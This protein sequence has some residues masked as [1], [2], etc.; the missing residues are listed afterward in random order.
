M[1]KYRIDV[2]ATAERQ[3]RRLPRT[4]QARI[5]RAVVA[6]STAPRPPGCR[7]LSGHDDVFRIRIGRYRVLYAIEDR[8][9]V[10]LV[11]KVGDRKDVYR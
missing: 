6:L 8:R 9:L 5:L 4:D 7:T 3:I 2:S 10:I 1:A 11:L